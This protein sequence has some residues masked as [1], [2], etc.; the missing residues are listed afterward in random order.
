MQRSGREDETGDDPKDDPAVLR[1][2]RLRAVSALTRL[3]KLEWT[4]VETA[5]G[6]E[7]LTYT[8]YRNEFDKETKGLRED[9]ADVIGHACSTAKI[10]LKRHHCVLLAGEPEVLGFIRQLMKD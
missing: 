9:L 1:E 10:G 3:H 8:F 2:L 4:D 5:S 7:R 6:G